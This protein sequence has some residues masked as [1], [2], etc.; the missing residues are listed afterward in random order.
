MLQKSSKVGDR[1]TEVADE[2][3]ECSSEAGRVLNDLLKGHKVVH[4]A[5]SWWTMLSGKFQW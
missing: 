4:K 1:V 2:D 3:G 5:I